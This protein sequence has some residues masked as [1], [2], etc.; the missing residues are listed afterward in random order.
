MKKGNAVRRVVEKLAKH[1]ATRIRCAS[2]QCPLEGGPETG[3]WVGAGTSPKFGQ[4]LISY[5]S[6][7][8]LENNIPLNGSRVQQLAGGISRTLAVARNKPRRYF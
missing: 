7:M 6:F 3:R 8:N 4:T 2:Q 1:H 5:S